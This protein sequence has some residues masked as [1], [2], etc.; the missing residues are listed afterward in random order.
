MRRR[1]D[2]AGKA[3]DDCVARVTKVVRQH[4]GEL[5]PRRRGVTGADDG[6]VAPPVDPLRPGN[7]QQRRRA[8][9]VLEEGR[10]VGLARGDEASAVAFEPGDLVLGL[11]D[12]GNAN[13]L[14][15]ALHQ[16]GQGSERRLGRAFAVDQLAKSLRADIVGTDQAEPGDALLRSEQDRAAGHG[17]PAFGSEPRFFSDPILGSVPFIS[18]RIL[19][20]CLK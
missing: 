8:G 6:D 14:A 3:G 17:Q 9:D 4:A 12:A 10:V 15:S 16:L 11:G 5:L 18:R 1:V 7:G 20:Q 13:A 2:A 19:G